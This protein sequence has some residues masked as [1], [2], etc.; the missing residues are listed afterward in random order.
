MFP[1]GTPFSAA[2]GIPESA[3]DGVILEV[4]NLV[5]VF[6]TARGDLRAVDGVSFSLRRGETLCLVGESGCGKSMTALSIMRLVPQPGGRVAGGRILFEGADLLELPES[7]IRSLR[8]ESIS[9]VFQEP[10]T[11]LNPVYTVGDQIAEMFRIH[12]GLS[13]SEAAGRTIEVMRLAGIPDA[14]RRFREYPHQLSG[15]M[16]QRIMIAMAMACEP[17]IIM[18]DEPTTALDTTIQAQILALLSELKTRSGMSMILIT[19]DLGVVNETA[20]HVV[21]MYGGRVFESAGVDA[22]FDRPLHPYTVALLK[23]VPTL[24]RQGGLEPIPGSVPDYFDLPAG[25]KFSDRCTDV[26]E[27]CSSREPELYS[28]EHGS[29]LVRCFKYDPRWSS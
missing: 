13:R 25:C 2:R 26:F 12:R 1:S 18:A 7:R 22:L 4:E 19:H 5:T 21:V 3:G 20:D 15:G 28:L 29:H 17:K 10:M 11:S 6:S 23:S 16:R 9:M 14:P 8:G 27:P 24:G